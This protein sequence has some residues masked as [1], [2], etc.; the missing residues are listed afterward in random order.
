M[1]YRPE[2]GS[3]GSV[4]DFTAQTDLESNATITANIAVEDPPPKYTPPPSY[5][6]ATGARSVL[7]S[8]ELEYC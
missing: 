6:T 7:F 5:T 2:M 4:L 3:A 1:L 8:I